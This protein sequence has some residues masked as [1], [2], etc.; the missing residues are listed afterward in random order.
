[1]NFTCYP[2]VILQDKMKK[3]F[4]SFID[5]Y[6][7][8]SHFAV[9]LICDDLKVCLCSNA[10]YIL[11]YN[12]LAMH[13][14]SSGYRQDIIEE[15]SVVPWRL[16]CDINDI[17]RLNTYVKFKEKKHK[18]YSGVSFVKKHKNISI[19]VAV[20]SNKTNIKQIF[21]FLDS[22]EDIFDLGYFIYD[23][24]FDDISS[25]IHYDLPKF[26]HPI[27]IDDNDYHQIEFMKKSFNDTGAFFADQK[28]FK[29]ASKE[30]FS[31]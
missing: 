17:E 6:F 18:L 23:E 31:I 27:L 5:G 20:A 24:F 2:S 29:N 30:R 8:I 19:N 26:K 4:K 14:Y 22:F 25:V 7:G 10:E 12:K 16:L 3:Y 1:M 21:T 28:L 13:R 9:N 15:L 11:D